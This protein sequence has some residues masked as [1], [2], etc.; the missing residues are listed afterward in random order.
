MVDLKIK[1]PEGFLNEEVR[2]GYKVSHEMKK[3]WAVELDLLSEFQRVCKKH[4]IKYIASGGTMLGAV[5]HKG[6]IPWDDDIDLMMLREEYEK[7]CQIAPSEFKHPYF[8]QNSHTDLGF[9]KGFSRL[10]NCETTAI[11]DFERASKF[12]I[13]QGIFIDIFPMDNV[14]D[15]EA[16]FKQQ[17]E[18]VKALSKK[19]ES[20][21]SF[22]YRC[23]RTNSYKNKILHL[24]LPL[25]KKPSFWLLRPDKMKEQEDKEI[26]R[27][28]NTQ[29]K[30]V[31][32][33]SFQFNNRVH[34]IEREDMNNLIES[35]FE[36]LK[37]PNI[38]NFDKALRWKFGDYMTP[39]N[40]PSYHQ[41]IFYDA[42]HCYKDYLNGK[43]KY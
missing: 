6:F 36:F 26:Q 16:L 29:T 1:L 20:R 39:V 9:T 11:F 22:N 38:A 7:L 41:G 42:D 12:R 40:S 5:R 4:N 33:L 21:F 31:G 35:D 43:L 13:N 27:Y 28:N 24:F 32:L 15:D 2:D 23:Y 30:Y 10:R 17:Y 19:V 37:I 18:N 34:D 14:I 25:I 3:V 8:F